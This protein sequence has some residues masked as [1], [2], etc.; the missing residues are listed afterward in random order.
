MPIGLIAGCSYDRITFSLA[1]GD[2][3]F[4]MSDGITE[5]PDPEGI[6]LGTEGLIAFLNK[7]RQLTSTALLESL[8]WDLT[9]Y[10]GQ[11]DFPDDVSGILFDYRGA[12]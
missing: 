3:L 10:A 8:I 5:C 12:G 2:R 6:E 1:A 9:D 4:L 11:T 7:S